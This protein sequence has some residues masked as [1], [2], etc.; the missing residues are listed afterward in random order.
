VLRLVFGAHLHDRQVRHVG[1][2]F[3]ASQAIYIELVVQLPH[4]VRSMRNPNEHS[5]SHWNERLDLSERDLEGFKLFADLF[6]CVN[7]RAFA[8][9]QV[10]RRQQGD[11]RRQVR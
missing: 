1:P 4:S 3:L 8:R 9:A 6:Q 10:S 7:G 2:F 5:R 11:M